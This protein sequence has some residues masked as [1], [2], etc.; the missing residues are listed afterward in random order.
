METVTPV[1]VVIKPG[2]MTTTGPVMIVLVK[3][4]EA[5]KN[6]FFFKKR[7][8]D[9]LVK[10]CQACD[11]DEAGRRKLKVKLDPGTLFGDYHPVI[12]LQFAL[13]SV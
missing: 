6:Y 12:D 5:G 8:E 2:E 7:N 13:Q 10:T 4:L 3:T 9:W 11:H 1:E